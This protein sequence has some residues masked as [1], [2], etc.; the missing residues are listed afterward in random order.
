MDFLKTQDYFIVDAQGHRVLLHG[1]NFGGWLMMEAYFTHAPNVAEQVFKKDFR[2]T[3]G[4][5]VLEQLEFEFRRIFITEEDFKTV[6]GWG[7]NV[8]RLPF[9]CR[10]IETRPYKYDP[11]GLKYLD[12]AVRLA[13][14][15]GLRVIL[16]LHAAPGAQNHDWH[17]DSLGSA[18]LWNNKNN[19]NRT[20]A[21][22][23]FLSDHFKDESAVVG[24][25]LLNEPIIENVK[26]L[27]RFYKELIKRIRRIDRKHILFVEGS[28][29]AQDISVLEDF[30]DDNLSLSVHYY[31]PLEFTFNFVPGLCYPLKSSSGV[32]DKDAMCLFLS[33]YEKLS[34]ARQVPIFVGE[35]G[36]NS[37]G[38]IYGEDKW[39]KDVL[40]CFDEFQFHRTYWTYKAV[41]SHMFPDGIL[42]YYPNSPWV[43]R[44]GPRSGWETWKDL[45]SSRKKDI[46]RSWFTSTFDINKPI[47]KV[48]TNV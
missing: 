12:K 24:Y 40:A 5:K 25:D 42:S 44:A 39:L 21:L 6:A 37:R 34:K 19:Q 15:H 3:L 31:A 18:D 16:D 26:L 10:L 35:Y 9:N 4:Q 38:G 1:V 17:S 28:R 43:N 20:Y 22:W 46:I 48:L 36:I 27:N 14:K 33:G 45:W 8:I 29:W 11:L 30:S 41:K 32:W 47:E 23:E 2:K 13:K 7:M